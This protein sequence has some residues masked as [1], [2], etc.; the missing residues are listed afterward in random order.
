MAQQR[1]GVTA[2]AHLLFQVRGQGRV[3]ARVQAGVSLCAG[4]VRW[5]ALCSSRLTAGDSSKASLPSS[6]T[7]SGE[8]A[9]QVYPCGGT[10]LVSALG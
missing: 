7:F 6:S 2:R 5:A 1:Q 9:G 4:G 8:G 10:A 3:G